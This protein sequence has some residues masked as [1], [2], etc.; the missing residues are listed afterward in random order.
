MR[1]IIACCL[2]LLSAT[3]IGQRN[4]FI[5]KG[6]I[7]SLDAPAKMYLRYS[8]HKASHH[9]SVILKRGVFQFSGTIDE[10]VMA[11]LFLSTNGKPI[12]WPYDELMFYIDTGTVIINSADSVKH[13]LIKGS[14]LNE[15]FVKYQEQFMQLR[16]KALSH[17]ALEQEA[18]IINSNFARQHPA[19]LVSLTAIRAISNDA[20]TLPA[21]D[22]L[23]VLFKGLDKNLQSGKKGQELYQSLQLKRKLLQGMVAPDFKQP[24]STGRQVSLSSLRGQYVLLDFW[25]SWCKPCRAANKALVKLYDKY[26]GRNL[27]FLGV[28]VDTRRDAWLKA[29]KDDQLAW[30]QLC[31]LQR[32][33]LAATVYQI[34]GVPTT[35]LLDPSG[36]IIARDIHGKALEDLLEQL[37]K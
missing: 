33:N 28:S 17:E 13:A 32:E 34:T 20:E 21:F 37:V 14:R 22:S 23:L 11:S 8:S 10:P 1:F 36:V 25:A 15:A 18:A 24:D 7:G 6:R 16:L 9:D 5:I 27:I 4:K 2:L 3:G 26:S 31:D 35:Y 12:Q 30:L 19:S 29:V